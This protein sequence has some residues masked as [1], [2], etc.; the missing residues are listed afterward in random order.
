MTFVWTP[1]YKD[2]V[3]PF[4]STPNKDNSIFSSQ[5]L[6]CLQPFL[7]K[8]TSYQLLPSFQQIQMKKRKKN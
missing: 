8:A 4:G 7:F 5:G 3:L 2:K 6:S 1:I